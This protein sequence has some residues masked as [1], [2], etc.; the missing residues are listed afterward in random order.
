MV[1]LASVAAAVYLV[2]SISVVSALH[3]TNVKIVN[4][5]T[6]AFPDQ[7]VYLPEQADRVITVTPGTDPQVSMMISGTT[8]TLDTAYIIPCKNAA[9][10]TDCIGSSTPSFATV[11]ASGGVATHTTTWSQVANHLSP[12]PS[13]S[14]PQ[15]ARFLIVT[16]LNRAGDQLVAAYWDQVVRTGTNIFEHKSTAINE[17]VVNA[18]SVD[19]VNDIKH[20]I[21]QN[22]AVPV[23]ADW[24]TSIQAPNAD[25]LYVLKAD[26]P[27]AGFVPLV[28]GTNLFTGLDTKWGFLFPKLATAIGSGIQLEKYTAASG[29]IGNGICES[30]E[31]PITACI[32]CGGCPN[33][34]VCVLDDGTFSCYQETMALVNAGTPNT[35][36]SNCQ[37]ANTLQLQFKVVNMLPG[38]SLSQARYSLGGGPETMAACTPV[39]NDTYQCAVV[40]PADPACSG[41][42]YV[43][44]PNTMTFV[45]VYSDATK[46]GT[47]T[48]TISTN[49][50]QITVG[51]WTCGNTVCESGLGENVQNC[52]KDCSDA[53][54]SGTVC[55]FVNP[56]N[57]DDPG[58][59]TTLPTGSN[60]HLITTNP[61]GVSGTAADGSVEVTTSI[62]LDNIPGG[63]SVGA[64]TCTSS[65]TESEG[66]ACQSTCSA[67]CTKGTVVNGVLPLTCTVP[68]TI[69]NG[70]PTKSYTHYTTLSFPT[71]VTTCSGVTVGETL[72]LSFATGIG[73]NYCGD[74]IAS[75][76]EICCIDTGCGAGEYCDSTGTPG[77]NDICRVLDVVKLD[78]DAV[79]DTAFV[80]TQENDALVEFHLVKPPT[81]VILSGIGC[82]FDEDV[83]C[84]VTCDLLNANHL[85]CTLTVPQISNYHDLASFD[86]G[87]LTA[88]LE[89]TIFVIAQFPDGAGEQIKDL[90]LDLPRFDISFSYL[91]HDGVCQADLGESAKNS[92][93]DCACELNPSFGPEYSCVPGG[94][95]LDSVCVP[96]SKISLAILSV[97]PEKPECKV[98]ERGAM[99]IFLKGFDISVKLTKVPAGTTIDSVTAKLFGKE[100]FI[101]C[102]PDGEK[103]ICHISPKPL[104]GV[105]TT[106]DDVGDIDTTLQID[107]ELKL[108]QKSELVAVTAKQDVTLFRDG[109]D[110]LNSLL[111]EKE[112]LE[113]D[114]AEE[115]HAANCLTTQ[116]IIAGIIVVGLGI[117]CYKEKTTGKA[118]P[119]DEAAGKAAPSIPPAEDP[120]IPFSAKPPGN[121]GSL[122]DGTVPNI[123]DNQG[124]LIPNLAPLEPQQIL[125]FQ[126]A[127]ATGAATGTS[128]ATSVAGKNWCTLFGAAL[129]I[130]A[131]YATWALP[132]IADHKDEAEDIEKEI[133]ELEGKNEDDDDEEDDSI[134]DHWENIAAIGTGVICLFG[135][136]AW[137]TQPIGDFG[138]TVVDFFGGGE[139]GGGLVGNTKA[140]A[141]AATSV[142][143]GSSGTSGSSSGRG[144]LYDFFT[145]HMS[146]DHKSVPAT[147][148]T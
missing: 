70:A 50:P 9:T 28:V 18:K 135:V 111:E 61:T 36:I 119:A 77:P 5:G 41:E 120:S 53:C 8:F 19:V 26:A 52:A 34:M 121:P 127:G 145:S 79:S 67:T 66:S 113:D 88:S 51:S 72:D 107:M 90:A 101:G 55:T 59:C 125:S 81:G 38:A 7:Q 27:P 73:T 131:C 93:L 32:D 140:T 86:E 21:E 45:M 129:T 63:Y 58:V 47:L 82:F 43:L 128:T 48:K 124:G 74:G 85:T 117:A 12:P 11:I 133:D 30:G 17:L 95:D 31:T 22:K 23:S 3:T 69:V 143:S 144:P 134:F 35:A 42:N 139:A 137:F 56:S 68:F 102:E 103:Y 49:F 33:Q 10:P 75:L 147:T 54:A 25:K 16:R 20:Y 97:D 94:D 104:E 99:C 96:Q 138:G 2:M 15:V 136:T 65:C 108:P 40:V 116:L 106:E 122:P 112:E 44:S 130:A 109:E 114:L 62:E 142:A 83:P 14:N 141:K 105:S 78:L 60:I 4:L 6:P 71:T 64:P 110:V 84:S 98:Q 57:P 92:C 76:G 13:S 132:A 100:T 87:A 89:P 118:S 91:E 29:S 24:V 1:V 39:S 46:Q 146:N 80:A 37:V 126:D 123:G 115:E 148:K